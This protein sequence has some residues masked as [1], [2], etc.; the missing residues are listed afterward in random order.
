MDNVTSV[1]LD[2]AVQSTPIFVFAAGEDDIYILPL[3]RRCFGLLESAGYRVTWHVE[4]G[5]AHHA[6]SRN[7]MRF[8]AEWISTSCLGL[9][10]TLRKRGPLPSRRH[11]FSAC[12]CA[13]RL[14]P[15]LCASTAGSLALARL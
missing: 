6:E 7:E 8:A 4:R 14:C 11:A 15:P 13:A 9:G 1:S 2:P 12:W 10:R 3:V 5:L